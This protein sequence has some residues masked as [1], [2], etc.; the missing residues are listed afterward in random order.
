MA[1]NFASHPTLTGFY[2]TFGNQR[3]QFVLLVKN[4]RK[5]KNIQGDFQM[6]EVKK[7]VEN[8][9][10]GLSKF[11]TIKPRREETQL[12]RFEYEE[13]RRKRMAR[14][15]APQSLSRW[16]TRMIIEGIKVKRGS[17]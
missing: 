1:R 5:I 6:N 3:G 17:A 14:G 15:A 9:E 2:T 10:K 4:V 12:I 7:N 16:L 13:A 8:V 11:F